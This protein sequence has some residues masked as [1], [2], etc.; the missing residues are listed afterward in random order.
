M[1]WILLFLARFFNQSLAGRRGFHR[2]AIL[3]AQTREDIMLPTCRILEFISTYVSA[4]T[5]DLSF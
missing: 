1:P 4:P 5:S 2:S 3:T